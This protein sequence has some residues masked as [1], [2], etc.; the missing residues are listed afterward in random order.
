MHW[1]DYSEVI[2]PAEAAMLPK[3]KREP[4]D[5]VRLKLI[6]TMMVIRLKLEPVKEKVVLTFSD[7]Y[8]KLNRNQ[9]GEYNRLLRKELK[10]EEVNRYME[11]TTSFHMQGRKE[12]KREGKKDGRIEGICD[13][14]VKVFARKFGSEPND[15]REKLIKMKQSDLEDVNYDLAVAKNVQQF[16]DQVEEKLPKK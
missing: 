16:L 15:L 2:N 14:I 6:V 13:A 12:G 5:D 3:M 9:Q 11:L 8:I 1:R 10:P 4:G 7:T